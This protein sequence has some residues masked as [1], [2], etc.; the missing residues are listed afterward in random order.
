VCPG[1]RGILGEQQARTLSRPREFLCLR[2]VRGFD[3]PE[4][5]VAGADE[6]DSGSQA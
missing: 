4:G 1:E 2:L 5:L 3:E 6:V